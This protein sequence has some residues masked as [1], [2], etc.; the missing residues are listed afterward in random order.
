MKE[1]RLEID[2]D[3]DN[4][5]G[6]IQLKLIGKQSKSEVLRRAIALMYEAV[7]ADKVLLV[8]N[9]IEQEVLIK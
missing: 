7:Q 4:M 1:Y 5:I 2:N 3:G 6:A 8:K 9:G